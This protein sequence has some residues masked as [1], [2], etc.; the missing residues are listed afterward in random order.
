MKKLKDNGQIVFEYTDEK[1]GRAGYPHNPNGSVEA[2]AGIC[3]PTGRV[4]GLM[5]HPERH[6]SPYQHPRWTRMRVRKE[7]DGLLVFRNGVDF[8]KKNL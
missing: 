6:I 1:G 3:D 5:P 7:G 4:F 8:A 2:I